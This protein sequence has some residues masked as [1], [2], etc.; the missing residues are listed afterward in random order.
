MFESVNISLK[1]FILSFEAEKI[2]GV[3]VGSPYKKITIAYDTIGIVGIEN[4]VERIGIY[5]VHDAVNLFKY[6]IKQM[7]QKLT[8]KRI[9][10]RQWPEVMVTEDGK[11]Y[12]YCRLKM[13]DGSLEIKKRY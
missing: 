5:S 12:I 10:I 3:E 2:E 1:N 11:Y 4:A 6:Q 7:Y 9:I 13:D 8:P